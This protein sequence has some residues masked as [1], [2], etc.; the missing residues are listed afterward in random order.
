LSGV[1]GI[2]P[3]RADTW[4]SRDLPVLRAAV[5]LHE[6]SGRRLRTSAIEKATG[7]DKETVQRA[8][9]ALYR[10]RYFEEATG[11]YGGEIIFVGEPTGEAL[12]HA[13]QWPSPE[14]QLRK[15][16][17]AF[18]LSPLMI[19]VM[20]KNAAAQGRSGSG[21]PQRCLKSPSAHSAARAET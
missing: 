20:R 18:E 15:L 14:V 16:I 6:E 8:L 10:E 21:W 1:S 7:F 3:P 5:E 19:R 13:E 2:L 17:A 9:R 4:E 12:R 11:R